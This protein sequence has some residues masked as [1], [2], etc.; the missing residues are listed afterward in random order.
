MQLGL[1]Q[2]DINVK[3]LPTVVGDK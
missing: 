2:S 1:Q 3:V